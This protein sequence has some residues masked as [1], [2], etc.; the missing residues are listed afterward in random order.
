MIIN[1][2]GSYIITTGCAIGGFGGIVESPTAQIA[3]F[4]GPLDAYTTGMLAARSVSRRLLS[5]YSSSLLRVRRSSDNAELSIG[6]ND[7]GNLNTAAML[8][9]VGAGN[10][11]ISIVYDQSGLGNN[12]VQATA[13]AQPQI[14]SGGVVS[15]HNG[16]PTTNGP[17]DA[18][19]G[20]GTSP[21]I[22]VGY[23]LTAWRNTPGTASYT[24]LFVLSENLGLALIGDGVVAGGWSI[25]DN[26][27]TERVFTDTL[28]NAP[29]NIYYGATGTAV[30]AR[31]NAQEIIQTGGTLVPGGTVIGEISIGLRFMEDAMYSTQPSNI[32]S[33]Q[34]IF[35]SQI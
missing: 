27:Y 15:T 35:L 33:V 6:F 10:G 20:S 3:P 21:S 9:F 8:A 13:A 2:V 30:T 16:H 12:L 26:T 32:S 22:N 17:T 23:F 11:F 24:T 28:Q 18:K 5:S 14:V 29:A 4:V 31:V 19:L 25:F 1:N 7:A 34:S